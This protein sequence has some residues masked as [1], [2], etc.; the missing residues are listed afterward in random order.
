MVA[1]FDIAD[2]GG[3]SMHV[4]LTI[5][6]NVSRQQ[7]AAMAVKRYQRVVGDFQTPVGPI[8]KVRCVCW[9]SV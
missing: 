3:N 5:D 1:L 7:A 2:A 8:S 6:V 4:P 9:P